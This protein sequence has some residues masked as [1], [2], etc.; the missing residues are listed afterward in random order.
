[1]CEHAVD[2][3][4]TNMIW[5]YFPLYYISHNFITGTKKICFVDQCYVR[6]NLSSKRTWQT[7]PNECYCISRARHVAFSSVHLRCCTVKYARFRDIPLQRAIVA[8]HNNKKCATKRVRT[9]VITF[10]GRNMVFRSRS[11]RVSLKVNKR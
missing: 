1:M 2:F 11:G 3:Q 8:W 4:V 10:N 5:N 9:S 7:H 6:Q